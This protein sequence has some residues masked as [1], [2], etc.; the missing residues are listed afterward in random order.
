MLKTRSA[1]KLLVALLILF[2]LQVVMFVVSG[3]SVMLQTDGILLA[4]MASIGI[5]VVICEWIDRGQE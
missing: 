1:R 2:G 3:V 4:A 5:F